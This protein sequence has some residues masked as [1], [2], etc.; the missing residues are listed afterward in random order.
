MVRRQTA[1][2]TRII[3]TPLTALTLYPISCNAPCIAFQKY[4]DVSFTAL[5]LPQS[6]SLAFKVRCVQDRDNRECD[7]ME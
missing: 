3:V 6:T 7:R 2:Q 1:A 4:Y 5:Y